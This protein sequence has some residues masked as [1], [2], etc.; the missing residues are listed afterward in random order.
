MS[1]SEHITTDPEP[2]L[3]VTGRIVRASNSTEILSRTKKL[4]NDEVLRRH[5]RRQSLI[6]ISRLHSE[7]RRNGY[8]KGL[9]LA[10]ER[11]AQAL[12]FVRELYR[13][14]EQDIIDLV[15]ATLEKIASDLPAKVLTPKIVLKALSE[16]RHSAEQVTISV[17]T[18]MVDLVNEQLHGWMENSENTTALNIVDDASLGLLDCRLDYGGCTVDAGLPVQI[19]A[20][21]RA[22]QDSVT[23][24]DDRSD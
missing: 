2:S 23:Q 11:T 14:A 5:G 20:L 1:N 4:E 10:A 13:T 21:R 6:E 18:D 17:H 9:E 22:L 19:D 15:L 7:A 16:V 3:L 24:S 12:Q 8:E